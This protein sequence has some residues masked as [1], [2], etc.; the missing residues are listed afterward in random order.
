MKFTKL[1]GAEQVRSW[2]YLPHPAGGYCPLPVNAVVNSGILGGNSRTSKFLS[3]S[4]FSRLRQALSICRIIR[5][6]MIIG[7]FLARL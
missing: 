6:S 1:T 7:K 3:W 5:I 4:G 2:S